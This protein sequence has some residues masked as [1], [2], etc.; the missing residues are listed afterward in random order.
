METTSTGWHTESDYAEQLPGVPTKGIRIYL[1]P[2]QRRQDLAAHKQHLDTSRITHGADVTVF[3]HHTPSNALARI[4][5]IWKT[6]VNLLG[7][8]VAVVRLDPEDTQLH[9]SVREVSCQTQSTTRMQCR[10]LQSR[11]RTAI[12]KLMTPASHPRGEAVSWAR[13][14]PPFG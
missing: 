8:D 13:A 1:A 6:L 11:A 9:Q 2:T 12:S 5:P 14:T 10:A 4:A 7:T 3:H